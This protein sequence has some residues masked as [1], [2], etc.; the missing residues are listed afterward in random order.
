MHRLKI[1]SCFW[2][3]VCLAI[4]VGEIGARAASYPVFDNLS[5]EV[6]DA[7]ARRRYYGRRYNR[8]RYSGGRNSGRRYNAAQ[9]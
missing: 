1:E 6:R 9:V 2:F 5:R 3:T 4:L 8:G 7:E